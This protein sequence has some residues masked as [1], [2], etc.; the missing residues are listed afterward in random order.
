MMKICTQCGEPKPNTTE[1]FYE[2]CYGHNLQAQCIVCDLKNAKA[3][4]DRAAPA[5]Y[6]CNKCG[7]DK[8]KDKMRKDVNRKHGI[9]PNCLA[10]DSK[11]RMKLRKYKTDR[12]TNCDIFRH[13]IDFHGKIKGG[14]RNKA[15]VAA[16]KRVRFR[17]A[18]F[19]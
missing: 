16:T 6:H 12:R 11:R 3:R 10:C 15:F 5:L 14:L 13:N 1:F 2:N 18:P 9:R 19:R 8:T 4:R 17:K 7:K